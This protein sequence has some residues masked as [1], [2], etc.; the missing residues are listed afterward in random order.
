MDALSHSRPTKRF[1]YLTVLCD[2]VIRIGPR[3]CRDHLAVVA[4]GGA[5]ARLHGLDDRD[6]DARLAQMQ[7]RG[8]AGEAAADDDDVRCLR[9]GQLGQFRSGWRDG[10]P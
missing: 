10:G 8:E 5:P 4:A 3:Q 7:R 6:I 2:D 9:A 1:A